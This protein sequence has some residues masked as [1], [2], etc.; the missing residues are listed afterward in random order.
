MYGMDISAGKCCSP[1]TTDD[2]AKEQYFCTDKI[3]NAFSY[4]K[5]AFCSFDRKKCGTE[6]RTLFAK[7]AP[8][9]I[10]TGLDFNLND[11]CPFYIYSDTDL[12]FNT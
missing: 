6:R 5:Y 4:Q 7:S 11:I 9:R 3:S 1:G 8:Q 2:C 10:Y 12:P